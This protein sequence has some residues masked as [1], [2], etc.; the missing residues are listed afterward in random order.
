VHFASA[1][2][3]R[4][5]Y[6]CNDQ[7]GSIYTEVDD[8]VQDNSIP[9]LVSNRGIWHKLRQQEVLITI[10]HQ[11]YLIEI[12]NSPL[13]FTSYDVWLAIK[14]HHIGGHCRHDLNLEVVAILHKH[15]K[16][17][18]DQSAVTKNPN[19]VRTRL[20]PP[21]QVFDH[22]AEFHFKCFPSEVLDVLSQ[23]P[24]CERR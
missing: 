11:G 3:P 5:W 7:Q 15:N 10:Y 1:C 23:K 8:R 6:A 24:G 13:H 20:L 19:A 18:L 17:Y 9:Y 12:L 4:R 2:E 21:V 14:Y 22:W 16:H